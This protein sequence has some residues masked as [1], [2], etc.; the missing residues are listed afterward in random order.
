MEDTDLFNDNTDKTLLAAFAWWERRRVLYNVSVGAAG[1][2]VLFRLPFFS[3]IDF[4]GVLL[5]GIIANLLYS[6]GFLTEVAAKHYLKSNIDFT[7]KRKIIFSIGIVG[8]ILL[9]ILFGELFRMIL[10]SMPG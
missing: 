4:V 7:E 5:F 2:F 3:V 10:F 6:L 1:I 9:T 8:S